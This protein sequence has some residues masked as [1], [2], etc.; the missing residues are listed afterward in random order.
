MVEEIC[1]PACM[2]QIRTHLTYFFPLPI[3]SVK[4]G[5]LYFYFLLMQEET[6]ANTFHKKSGSTWAASTKDKKKC[7]GNG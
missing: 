1:V 6:A 4:L 2:F 5:R 3:N 7:K